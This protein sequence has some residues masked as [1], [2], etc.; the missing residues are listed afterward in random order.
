MTLLS[1]LFT[2]FGGLVFLSFAYIINVAH[3]KKSLFENGLVI[4]EEPMNED[5]KSVFD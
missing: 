3:V 5:R 4:E 2:L 1:V